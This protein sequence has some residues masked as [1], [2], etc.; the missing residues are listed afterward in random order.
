M[1]KLLFEAVVS[2]V[3]VVEK[4][5]VTIVTFD[6]TCDFLKNTFKILIKPH[7]PASP[8]SLQPFVRELGG[9]RISPPPQGWVRPI[10]HAQ[11]GA[12][13]SSDF[14][15]LSYTYLSQ[16]VICDVEAVYPSSLFTFRTII[17]YS[18]MALLLYISFPSN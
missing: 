7:V 4:A 8:A 6:M 15:E 18:L 17:L 11:R 16:M 2:L 13:L 3:W 10:A 5:K 9:G 1:A 14:C 12:G